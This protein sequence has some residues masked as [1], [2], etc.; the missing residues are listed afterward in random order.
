MYA[1]F[2]KDSNPTN[3]SLALPESLKM[4]SDIVS[5]LQQLVHASMTAF[6]ESGEKNPVWESVQ[7]ETEQAL[8]MA[9]H[10]K[11]R[12]SFIRAFGTAEL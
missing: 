8:H 3:S 2:N 1:K 5:V 10:R 4:L 12:E 6:L 9:L 7:M 11:I